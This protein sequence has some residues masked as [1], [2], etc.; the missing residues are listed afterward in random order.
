MAAPDTQMDMQMLSIDL[1]SGNYVDA[2][3]DALGIAVPALPAS[4]VKGGYKILLRGGEKLFVARRIWNKHHALPMFLGGDASQVLCKIPKRYH[5]EFHG[6]LANRLKKAGFPLP[7]GGR[8][9]S[10]VD[11]A[12]YMNQ[13][14][15]SQRMAFDAVLDASRNID[16]KYG[17][18]ITQEVWSRIMGGQFTPYP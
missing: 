2:A 14:P 5:V 7:V 1:A 15:G 16:A 12:N 8:G 11:W 10:A 3:L 9:G 17:T 18:N 13:H 4:G 6:I